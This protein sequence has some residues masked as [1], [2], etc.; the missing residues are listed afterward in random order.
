M[1]KGWILTAVF[2]T[3]GMFASSQAQDKFGYVEE[4]YVLEQMPEYKQAEKEMKEYAD[5][6]K[7]E[8]DAKQKDLETKAKAF[9]VLRNNKETPVS[10]LETK[11][12]E[13]QDLQKQ[14]GELQQ[15]IQAEYQ[16]RLAKKMNP[17]YTKVQKAVEDV[18][19]DNGNMF[20]FRKEALVYQVEEN[21]ASDLVIRKLGLTPPTTTVVGRGNLKS[22]NKIGYFDANVV[23]PQLPDYKKAESEM[24]VF[25]KMLETDLGNKRKM[26]EKIAG[27]MQNTPNMP[28]ATRKAKEAEG[29]KLV[30]Q[31]QEA[32]QGFQSKL[33]E[34]YLKLMEPLNKQ[35]QDKINEIAKESNYTFIFKMEASLYEPNDANVSDAILKKFG[36]TPATT[37]KT[38]N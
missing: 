24:A 13:L 35:V 4:L 8:I 34:K 36:V 14:I 30:Q 33:Q 5:A 22:S 38:G 27:E 26:I 1:K 23:I 37:N 21:N 2:A 25:R 17:V 7:A 15:V 20:I 11:Y 9:D 18:S 16:D 32:E 10:L 31:Y 19:K 12:K 29:Q 6:M 28:E 3:F